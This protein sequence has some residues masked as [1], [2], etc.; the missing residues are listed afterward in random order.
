MVVYRARSAPA[1]S[2]AVPVARAVHI[3][4]WID[5]GAPI[6]GGAFA[7]ASGGHGGSRISRCHGWRSV[8]HDVM[9]CCSPCARWL[10]AGSLGST[11]KI[12]PDKLTPAGAVPVA[13]AV[14]SSER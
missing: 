12:D 6:S 10:N 5:P 3:Q 8:H 9:V 2:A 1:L 14:G 4:D 11:V 13:L 7:C